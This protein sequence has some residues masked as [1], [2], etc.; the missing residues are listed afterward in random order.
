[1]KLDQ[2]NTFLVA[3]DT[4]NFTHTARRLYLSQS[5]VSQQI[6]ELE[7][8][9]GITLFERRG[10]GLLLSP[11]GERLRLLVGPILR[12]VKH[13]R[14]NM[15]EFQ[16]MPQGVLRIGASNMPGVYLLP[17]ALGRFSQL[18]PGVMTSLGVRNTD[19]I[20]S[21]IHAGE[22]DVAV[23]EDEPAAS[24]THGWEK[25]PLWHDELVLIT[26]PEHPWARRGRIRLDAL[27][28][29][30]IIFRQKDS[31]TRQLILDRLSQVGMA[32][33]HLTTR[34]EL[35]NTESI[36]HAVMAGL[37]VG[38]VSRQAVAV[39]RRAGLLSEVVVEDVT[40]ERT[41]WL[42]KPAPDKSFVHLE[43]FCEM[44]EQKDWLPD[45]LDLRRHPLD[46]HLRVEP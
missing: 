4:L 9:L 17:H 16:G 23:V 1:M 12:D 8:D 6:R 42:L 28:G 2:L 21:L 40:I 10:R 26:A 15:S 35:D 36:K 24:R 19:G 25:A 30:P 7:E 22:L 41:L 18:F 46:I 43:R 29:Q 11:A 34:F 44:L 39:E 31:L 32:P 38:F 37:G 27:R 33:E 20:L 5:A 3:A 13:V 14:A 45:A